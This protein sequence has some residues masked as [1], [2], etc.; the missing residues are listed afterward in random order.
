[1][2]TDRV[3]GRG[4]GLALDERAALTAGADLGHA[5]AVPRLG[6]PAVRLTDGPNGARGA[7][8]EPSGPTA[9]CLPCGSA[10]RATWSP[11]VVAAV[12]GVIGAEARAQGARGVLATT[13]NK[14]RSPPAGRN[15]DEGLRVID[16][17]QMTAKHRVA[18]PA[19]WKQ[20][21]DVILTGAVTDDEAKKLFP[22]GWKAIK[23]YLRF[24]R[25]SAR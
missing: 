25:P 16:S 5:A 23:P 8:L 6:I 12:G 13:V 10:L 1:M 9:A 17:L 18:T 21:E 2:A 20:G 24:V 3:A 15:F 7:H 11:D 22:Q 14:H 4:A 19:N